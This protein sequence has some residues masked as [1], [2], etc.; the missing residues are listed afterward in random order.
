MSLNV[1]ILYLEAQ[2]NLCVFGEMG[3]DTVQVQWTEN[4]AGFKIEDVDM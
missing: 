4:H 1:N 2:S 3:S